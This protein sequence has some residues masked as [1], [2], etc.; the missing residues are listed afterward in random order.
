[1]TPRLAGLN[2]VGRL[3][4]GRGGF[5]ARREMGVVLQ[6]ESLASGY[7]AGLLQAALALGLVGGLAYLAL[8]YLPRGT[9]LGRRGKL[10]AIEESLR[11]DARSSLLIVQVEGRRLLVATH[12]TA[13]A[14]LLTELDAGAGLEPQATRAAGES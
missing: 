10:L 8:R 3:D 9:L 14:T 6:A 11:L 7:V 13:G 1:L 12:S 2:W 4:S 5:D